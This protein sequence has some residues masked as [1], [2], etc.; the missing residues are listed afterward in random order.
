MPL[1]KYHLVVIKERNGASRNA[2]IHGWFILLLALLF[3]ALFAGN[4][5]LWEYY[6]KS[7]SLEGRLAETERAL[8]ERQSQITLMLSDLSVIREDLMRVQQF[9]T[10]LRLMMDMESEMPSTGTGGPGLNASFYAEPGMSA[11]VG[12][13][14]GT[15][16][17]GLGY[18]PL[19]RQDLAARKMR[20]FLKSLTEEVR[21]EEVR[22]QEILLTMRENK[23]TL[24]AIPSIWPIEGFVTSTFG[25]R[26]SPFTGRW[27]THTGMDIS[28]KMGTPIYATANG[29]VQQSGNDGAY[30]ISVEIKHGGGL[31]TKYGHMQKTA[32]VEGQQVKRGELIGYVGRTGRATGPHVHYEVRLSGVATNPTQYILD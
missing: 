19:H 4:V 13:N 10:K 32:V 3:V 21:L 30:G 12:S 17:Q 5:F 24:A 14:A 25:T 7:K 20:Q 11:S 9:D 29:T 2:H 1:G 15:V 18:I 28:A 26:A 6:G 16:E 31:V 8:N 27:E 22:Q 23:A